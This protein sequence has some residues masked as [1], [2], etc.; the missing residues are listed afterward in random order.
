MKKI[1]IVVEYNPFHNGHLYQIQ[2]IKEKF[3]K[4]CFISVVM[5]GDFV[6]RGEVSFLNKWEKTRIA[7]ENEV[8]LVVELPVYYAIQNAEIFSKMAVKILDYLGMEIQVF[9]AENDEIKIFEEIIKLQKSDEYNKKIQ[10]KIKNGN[11]YMIA[12]K[13]VLQEF[14]YEEFIKSNNILGLEYVRAILQSKLNIKPYIIK[15][16][17]SE[18]N[19]EKVENNRIKFVSASF[20]RKIFDSKDEKRWI[21][22]KNFIPKNIHKFLINKMYNRNIEYKNIK[23]E[24]LKLVKYRMVIDDKKKILGIFDMTEQLYS[25]IFNAIL[26]ST[27]YETFYETFLKKI[28][29]KNISLKRIDRILLN[30]LLDIRKLDENIDYIRVLGFNDIGREYLKKLKKEGK[31]KIFVNWKDIEKS[32]EICRQKIKIEKNTFILKEMI[33]NEKEKLNPIIK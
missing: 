19:E 15:R 30:I 2:K 31:D 24:F 22:L 32:K 21:E 12:Q 23:N 17:I 7:L 5:S 8:D 13:M 26:N 25:R 11:R 16:E 18:Y 3:G 6:Q 29:A 4:D 20:I 33:L 28:K 14:G 9:G 27:N 10:E 1:G